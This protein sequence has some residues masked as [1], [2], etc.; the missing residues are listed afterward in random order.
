MIRQEKNP[1]ENEV[2]EDL[3]TLSGLRNDLLLKEAERGFI[4]QK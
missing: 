2:Q 1:V 4:M 3:H